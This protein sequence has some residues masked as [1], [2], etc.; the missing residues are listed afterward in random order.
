MSLYPGSKSPFVLT[1]LCRVGSSGVSVSGTDNDVTA[2]NDPT[3]SIEDA[4]DDSTGQHPVL[5]DHV[6]ES[7]E[8]FTFPGAKTFSTHETPPSPSPQ[9]LKS[10]LNPTAIPFTFRPAEAVG[11]VEVPPVEEPVEVSE[12]AVE[13]VQAEDDSEDEEFYFPGAQKL[14]D[15]IPAP[16]ASPPPP[17]L[18]RA[19]S[20]VPE[21]PLSIGP[22]SLAATSPMMTT[23]PSPDL[24][25]L[26]QDSTSA[27]TPAPTVSPSPPSPSP[28]PPPRVLKQKPTQAQLEALYAAASSNDLRLLQSLF[29]NACQNEDVEEFALANDAAVRTG[30]TA[31]HAAA[32][33]GYLEIVQWRKLVLV[34]TP[35]W[36]VP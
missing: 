14:P 32:S 20:P 33:R 9:P 25:P 28:P 11:P 10:G 29:R 3:L 4:Q 22:S 5:N 6:D 16:V 34:R 13:V 30:L 8:E 15:P 24:G 12:P 31:L 18:A 7:D 1:V 17:E 19:L 27:S 35:V 2:R 21:N 26:S 23:P 36:A